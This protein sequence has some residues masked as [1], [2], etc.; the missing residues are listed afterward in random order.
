[1]NIKIDVTDT[2][3]MRGQRG[4]PEQCPAALAFLAAGIN[5]KVFSVYIIWVDKKGHEHH[6]YT[7]KDFRQWLLKFDYGE[8][9]LPTSFEIELRDD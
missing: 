5:A 9:V 2:H 1:M 4:S 8:Q 6:T 3:I 7:P